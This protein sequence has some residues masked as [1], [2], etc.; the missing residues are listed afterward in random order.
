MKLLQQKV[1]TL[2][3]AVEIVLGIDERLD[4]I[5]INQGLILSMLNERKTSR[6]LRDYEFKVFSQWGEDGIIQHLIESV[7]ISNK[8]FIEFGIEDFRESNC[9]FLMMKDNWR[10]FVVDGSSEN[11]ERLRKSYFYWKYDLSSINMFITKENI[12]ELLEQSGFEED[13]GI[14][15]VD[16]D[17]NDYHVLEAITGLK[18]RILICEY[19]PVFGA[20][21]K[22]TVPYERDFHRTTKHHS[23]LYYGASL[24][25]LTDLAGKKGYTLVGVNS[26]G[27][28]AF[29]VRSDLMNTRLAALSVEEAY[30]PS[31]TRQ[32]RDENGVLTYATGSAQL[33]LM[34]G[35]SVLNIDSNETEYL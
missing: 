20:Y 22:I 28:N 31:Q 8:T 21:R 32:S 1:R 14:L 24:A 12:N 18:P 34:S 19:N 11:I 9:R 29:Y 27:V 33:Q 26:A 6:S 30:V 25:A 15:S 5:R 17:G 13:L 16:I 7:E 35:M 23:N 10:G 4:G 3:R 2:R